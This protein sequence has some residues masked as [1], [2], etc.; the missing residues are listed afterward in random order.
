MSS[1]VRRSVSL[2]CLHEAAEE[3]TALP[4]GGAEAL[5]VRGHNE[6]V[7]FDAFDSFVKASSSSK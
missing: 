4:P 3:E 7:L 6:G 2:V 1:A 5:P